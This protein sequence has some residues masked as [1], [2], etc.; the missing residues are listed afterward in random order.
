LWSKPYPLAITAVA[1]GFV[2]LTAGCGSSNSSSTTAASAGTT[3]TSATT[4]AANAGVAEAQ[5]FVDAHLAAPTSVGVETAVAKAPPKGKTVVY[6]DCGVPVC[7]TVGAG[8][9]AATEKL[10]W[11]F[12]KIVAGS[13]PEQV[14]NAWQQVLQINPGAV[15]SA[16][17]PEVLFAKQL[18]EYKTKGGVYVGGSVLD[19]VGNGLVAAV[20]GRAD[21]V[22]T[23][24]ADARWI[25]AD[26]KGKA[27]ALLYSVPDFPVQVVLRDAFT[28][29]YKRLCPSCGLDVQKVAAASIGKDLPGKVVSYLQKNPDTNYIAMGF[30]DMSVGVPEA[31]RAAGLQDKVKI[32]AG[33]ASPVN[34]QHVKDGQSEKVTVAHPDLMSGWLMVDA[35][36]RQFTG[37]DLPQAQYEKL[38]FQY[39]TADTVGDPKSPYVGVQ[40]YQHRFEKLWTAAG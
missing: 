25:I 23:G 17:I 7:A 31:L 20:A 22:Q 36:V 4:S 21:Y 16:G 13:V 1:V 34:L 18:A 40:D 14:A 33:Y 27:N 38:P 2:L 26:S 5:K 19:P 35:L 6:L 8:V 30:G 11:K 39:L 29:D 32:V 9:R 3:S 10:G 37:S 24:E 12:Q 15:I 28:K